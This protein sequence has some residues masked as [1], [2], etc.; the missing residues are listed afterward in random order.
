M[1]DLSQLPPPQLL[2]SLDFEAIY[3]RKLEQFKAIYPDWSAVLESDPVVKLLELSAYQELM[4]R[5]WVNDAAVSTML[6]YARGTDLD[7]KA[8]DYGVSRLLMTPAN[9]DAEPPIEAV[10]EED[11]R[12]RYR[13]QMALE[14]LSVAGS[15]GAYLFH[16]LSAS[17]WVT[18]ASVDSPTFAAVPVSDALRSQLPAGALVLVC[19]DAAGLIAPLPGDVS[20]AVLPMDSSINGDELAA[21]VQ[22]ALSAD[23]VRPL[24]DRP[25]VSAGQPTV[26][27]VQAVIE[28]EN[29]PDS[30]TVMAEARA[31]LNSTLASTRKLGRTLSRSAIFAALHVAGVSRVVLTEPAEDIRCDVRHFP[32]CDAISLVAA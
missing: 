2:E 20:I 31:G 6:A 1:I 3:A 32:Q 11:E 25:R 4:L 27:R 5:A 29:G 17:A 22:V 26:F 28:I 9:P 8:A 13:C 30:Q 18:D 16:S 19:S 10:Y 12:L 23:D 14:G 7:N 24:T 15:R 21:A